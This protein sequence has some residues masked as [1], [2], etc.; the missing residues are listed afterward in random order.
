[1]TQEYFQFKFYNYVQER[2]DIIVVIQVKTKTLV[3]C[4]IQTT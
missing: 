3:S 2:T 1:M 4:H